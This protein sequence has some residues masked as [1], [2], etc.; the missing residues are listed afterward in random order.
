MAAEREEPLPRMP[1][2]REPAETNPFAYDDE[3]D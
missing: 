1:V 3:D 2:M